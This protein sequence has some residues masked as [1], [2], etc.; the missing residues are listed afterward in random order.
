MVHF[1]FWLLMCTYNGALGILIINVASYGAFNLLL[2]NV[3]PAMVHL[4]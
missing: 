1:I 4:I 2:I 3:V